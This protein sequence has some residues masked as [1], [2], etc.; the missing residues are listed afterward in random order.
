MPWLKRLA[1]KTL[2]WQTHSLNVWNCRQNELIKLSF[3]ITLLSAK[4]EQL[5]TWELSHKG[6]YYQV[7]ITKTESLRTVNLKLL[8]TMQCKKAYQYGVHSLQ[9]CK[10]VSCFLPAT[11]SPVLIVA[12]NCNLCS[13][14]FSCLKI[15]STVILI[16]LVEHLRAIVP[17]FHLAVCKMKKSKIPKLCQNI[18]LDKIFLEK[19]F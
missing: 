14:H 6:F 17:K 2:Y 5:H 10:N 4:S 7:Q 9:F 15:V 8:C 13:P 19:I 16:A 11:V 1:L 12:L 18:G 3:W